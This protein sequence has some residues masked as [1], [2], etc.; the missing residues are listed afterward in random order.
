MLQSMDLQRVG[1]DLTE[2]QQQQEIWQDHDDLNLI[3][4][5]NSILSTQWIL[6][7]PSHVYMVIQISGY[8]S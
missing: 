8:P 1:H 3:I 5:N 4:T 2:Q 7:E 6:W